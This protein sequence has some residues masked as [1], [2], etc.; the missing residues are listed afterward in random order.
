MD[1]LAAIFINEEFTEETVT[2]AELDR[3]LA[4]GWR[5]FGRQFFRYNLAVYGN[6][7]RRVIP[8][9]IRLSEFRL[10]KSQRRVLRSNA[11]AN[12]RVG[13]VDIS[14]ELEDLFDRHKRRFKKHPPDS[15]YTFISAD[16]GIEPC[17]T[18]QQSVRVEG[19][20]FAA[21]FFDAGERSLSGIYTAFEPTETRRSL[22]IFTILKEIEFA[23]D[24]GKEF[25]YQGYCYSGRSFYDY[26]KRFFGTEAYA[27]NGVW[28]PLP[29]GLEN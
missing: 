8:L 10:S 4:N 5:H 19:K 27:W 22:G 14:P 6:E 16:P 29:R 23:I 3:L 26:K 25:Y 17:E 28:T 21:G 18:L 24:T 13:P 12:V 11:D 15:V 1:D 9:R 2:R 7:I 20:L